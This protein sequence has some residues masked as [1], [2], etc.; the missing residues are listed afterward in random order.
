METTVQPNNSPATDFS[1]VGNGDKKRKIKQYVISILVIA[2]FLTGVYF[3]ISKFEK[4][5]PLSDKEKLQLLEQLK[6]E[7][8]P[9]PTD[10]QKKDLLVDLKNE[11]DSNILS[12]EEKAALLSELA[13]S[14]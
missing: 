7:A 5:R 4:N 12:D 1:N 8:G 3:L 9:G 6:A 13:K 2:V 10:E 14:E 11:T